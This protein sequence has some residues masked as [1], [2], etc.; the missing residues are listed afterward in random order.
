MSASRI[1]PKLYQGSLPPYGPELAEQGVRT[2]VLC[3]KEWQPGD[4]L[5]PGVEVLRCPYEDRDGLM[6]RSDWEQVSRMASAVAARVRREKR[7]LV[8]CAAGLNRSGLVTALALVELYGC[9]GSEAV[10]WVRREREGALFN[11]TFVSYLERIPARHARL[12]TV[13][14]APL[15]LL[16]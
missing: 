13:P 3:A 1:A 14:P 15:I 9:S 6:S 2:L 8:T 5:F 11:K 16:P 7:T 10:A 4:N 12:E